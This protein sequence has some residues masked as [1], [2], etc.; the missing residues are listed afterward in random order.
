MGR[1]ACGR[2]RSL[3]VEDE[4]LLTLIKLRHDFP[5]SDLGHRFGVTQSTVSRIFS[6][7][8]R[9]L[10]FSFKEVN[11]W[12]S[13][14]LVNHYMPEVFKTKYPKT[15]VVIDATEFP[16]EKP[17]NPVIQSSTWS[18]YKNRNTLKLLVGVTPNGVISFLSGL[19]GG[20]ISDKELTKQCGILQKL[21]EGDALMADRGF[22]IASQ[23]PQGVELNIPPFLGTRDQLEPDE[24][25]ETRRIATV[26]I[27]VECA[28]E[29]IKNFRITHFIP[30]G[31]CPLAQQIVSVC[32]FL[33]NF[34]EPLVP[35]AAEALKQP[36]RVISTDETSSSVSAEKLDLDKPESASRTGG[37]TRAQTSPPLTSPPLTS[38]KPPSLATVKP[39]P[40]ATSSSTRQ[41]QVQATTAT[42]DVFSTPTCLSCGRSDG[43]ILRTCRMCHRHYH[44]MC[45]VDDEDGRV[46][47]D[48]FASSVS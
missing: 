7:C 42:A 24:V 47:N 9:C 37:P 17:A 46:C 33:T 11:I 4:L 48:C 29:R 23:L 45:Q 30:A 31:L 8:L 10:Y 12:P 2:P 32:A 44:H 21:E 5:E 3:C 25:T 15:R 41:A 27:Y 22:D 18:N 26:R 28:I 36:E 35:P 20:R 43:P 40:A 39:A 38:V 1:M 13:R 14:E 16:I 19:Y 6:A 34:M